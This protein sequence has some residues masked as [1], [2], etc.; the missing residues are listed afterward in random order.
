MQDITLDKLMSLS[1]A[2]INSFSFFESESER[3]R[4]KQCV[5]ALRE[6]CS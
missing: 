6:E 4:L 5:A 2:K 3:H 1:E